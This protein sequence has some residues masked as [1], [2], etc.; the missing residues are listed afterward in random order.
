MVSLLAFFT[1]SLAGEPAAA[2]VPT[3]ITFS[4]PEPVHVPIPEPKV[5]IL[6]TN[7]RLTIEERQKLEIDMLQKIRVSTDKAPL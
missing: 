1:V 5:E 4:D 2:P 3:G 6:F 7:Q